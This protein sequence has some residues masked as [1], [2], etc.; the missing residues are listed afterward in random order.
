[1][2]WLEYTVIPGGLEWTICGLSKDFTEENGYLEAG[3][4]NSSTGP[5][6]DSDSLG[7]PPMS[8]VYAMENPSGT[9]VS[10]TYWEFGSGGTY[11]IWGYTKAA[12]GH[13]YPLGDG[14]HEVTILPKQE[15]PPPP[16]YWYWSDYGINLTPGEPIY[17]PAR[18]WNDFTERVNAVSTYLYGT[19]STFSTVSP[20][21]PMA[22]GP[23]WEAISALEYMGSP[24]PPPA[25]PDRD[26]PIC[27]SL[28]QALEDSLNGAIGV[29][30][31]QY[32]SQ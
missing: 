8:C 32:N 9:S 6:F 30:W 24:I 29:A 22:V 19:Y 27:A 5:V 17:F 10:G 3:I 1:M 15:N 26:T 23:I 20:R 12:N 14:A 31:N 11:T 2:A 7:V 21:Q 28:F 18:A 4:I 16:D 25:Y 13:Y